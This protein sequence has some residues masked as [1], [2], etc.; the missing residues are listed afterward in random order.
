MTIETR[1][2]ELLAP[3]PKNPR[4]IDVKAKAGL[5]RSMEIFGDVSGIVFNQRTGQL[6][7]GHQ[8]M[9]DLKAAGA[10]EWYRDE[11]GNAWIIHPK[12]DERFAIRMVYWDEVTQRMANMAANNPKTQGEFTDMALPQLHSLEAS[13][14]FEELR[15]DDMMVDLT[16]S[17]PRT[18]NVDQNGHFVIMVTCTGEAHQSELLAKFIAEGLKVRAIV[19]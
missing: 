9:D 2:I 6:V 18:P 16:P 8:R 10:T 3:D 4:R 19:Q 14:M 15:L 12:T 13:P 1:S 17:T 5:G 11:N 7:G